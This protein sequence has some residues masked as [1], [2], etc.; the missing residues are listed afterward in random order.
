MRCAVAA[1][2][3]LV[4][5]A[6]C[7]STGPHPSEFEGSGRIRGSF[8][9]GDRTLQEGWVEM[10]E[11]SGRAGERCGPRDCGLQVEA[12]LT[13]ENWNPGLWQVNPPRVPGWKRPSPIVIV[14][15]TGKLTTVHADYGSP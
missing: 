15:E 8:S 14:V 6:G 9:L 11:L 7:S 10:I 4:L 5:L 1:A 13:G 12:L 2:V 3:T